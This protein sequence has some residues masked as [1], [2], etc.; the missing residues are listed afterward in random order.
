MMDLQCWLPAARNIYM[1]LEKKSGAL[2]SAPPLLIPP[3]GESKKMIQAGLRS[4]SYPTKIDKKQQI[5]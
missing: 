5:Q 3:G 2:L 4:D 1:P